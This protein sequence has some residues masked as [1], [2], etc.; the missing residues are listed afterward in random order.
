MTHTYDLSP[1]PQKF[2]KGQILDDPSSTNNK[3]PEPIRTKKNC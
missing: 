3:G 2:A 1:S